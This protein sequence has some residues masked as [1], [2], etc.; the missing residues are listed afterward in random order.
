ML[1]V[2][3]HLLPPRPV[4]PAALALLIFTEAT[5]GVFI[6]MITQVLITAVQVGG[7]YL[8]FQIGISNAFS[9]DLVSQQQSVVLTT[10]FT[11]LALV[12]IFVTDLDHQMI[13]AMVDSYALFPPGQVLPLG[14]FSDVMA[15]TLAGAF[16]VGLRLSAPLLAFGL[17]FYAAMGLLTRLVPQMQVFFVALPVQVLFGLWLTMVALPVIILVFLRYFANGIDVYVAP[18]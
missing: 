5:V 11:N 2:V 13:R 15:R 1:P 6:G 3:G 16:T 10:F 4:Q 8:S 14:D 12:A 17:I 18:G 7:A 9:F